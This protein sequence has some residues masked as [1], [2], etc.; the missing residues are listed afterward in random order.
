[1]TE[2]NTHVLFV[3][4]SIVFLTLLGCASQTTSVGLS[5]EKLGTIGAKI[6][7]HPERSNT[8]LN[9]HDLKREQFEKAIREVSNDVDMSRRYRQSFETT[10]N[11]LSK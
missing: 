11:T 7:V 5:P 9:N 3:F 2:A 6:Q 1:M 10:M 4:V 8:I